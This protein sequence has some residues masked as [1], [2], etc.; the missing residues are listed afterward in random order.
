MS[1]ASSDKNLKQDVEIAVLAK[2]VEHLGDS[3]DSLKISIGE[4]IN[5]LI[6]IVKSFIEI[7]DKKIDRETYL[8]DKKLHETEIHKMQEKLTNIENSH[9]E[10][11]ITT[12]AINDER[13]KIW[14][15]SRGTLSFFVQILTFI[16]LLVTVLQL[17]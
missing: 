2:E 17:F 16:T 15:M 4:R 14:G 8:A 1:E 7:A 12:N 10:M 9:R 5:S 3:V 11:Q 13:K 6:D